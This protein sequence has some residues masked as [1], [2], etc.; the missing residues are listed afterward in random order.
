MLSKI[1][2]QIILETMLRHMENKEVIDDSQLGFSKGKPCLTNLVAFSDGVRALLD[3]G[4][5]TDV[6]YLDSRKAFDTV[7]HAILVSKLERQGFDG[8]NTWQIRNWLD[9]PT[10]RVAVS[11]LISKWRPATN[12]V[13][14]ELVLGSVLFTMFVGNMDS[15]IECTLSKVADDTKLC[16]TVDMLEGRDTIQRDLDRLERWAHVNFMKFN[17]AKCKVLHLG[18]GNPQH[19][20]SLGR[21]WI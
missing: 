20:Y 18:W 6:V 12:G 9:G 13:P 5:A 14:Q 8:W 1:V 10:Q 4:K 16:G 2:E 11:G 17:R 3:K 15:E 7:P 21:E 19:K